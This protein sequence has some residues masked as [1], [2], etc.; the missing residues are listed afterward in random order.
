VDRSRNRSASLQFEPLES[1]QMMAVS[2][3]LTTGG[4]L[5][6]FGSKYAEQVYF[7]QS[8]GYI[9]VSGVSQVWSTS[10][11][12][13][14]YVDMGKGNDVVSFN[15]LGNGGNEALAEGISVGKIKGKD[16]FGCAGN[17]N[18]LLGKKNSISQAANGAVT[19]NGLVQSWSVPTPPN[20]PSPPNPPTPP[21]PTNW[22]DSNVIDAALRSL[23]HNLYTDGRI[24]RNDMIN[25]LRNAEDGGIIDSTELNDLRSV[26]SNTTLFGSFDYVWKLSSYV[27]N[28]N[29]ANAKYQGTTLGNLAAGSTTAQMEKLI[30]KWF[31]GLDRP[32]AGGTYRQFTGQL[33]VGGAAYTDIHQGA[34]G[35]CYFVA[36]LG[37]TALKNPSAIS[38][39][40]VVNGDG[41]YTVR[42]YNGG[43]A[44][45]VTVDSYLPT[46]GAGNLIYANYGANYNNVNAE[47]WTALAEKAYVQINE[48]GWL[49]GGLPGNGQNAY[50]AIEGG[51]IYQALGQITGQGTTP[52]AFTS[53]ATSFTTFVNAW[54]QGKSIGFASKPTPASSSVVGSHAYAV[55]GY[56]ATNQTITLFNPWGIEYGLVTM[57][58]AQ[59][60]QNFS[61]FDRTV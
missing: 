19:V 20:P 33:F 38:N 26:V 3:T 11:V 22:F 12:N 44:Q 18:Y 32:T 8:N 42:F 50:S 15:S 56:N 2:A 28:A 24:D 31:L 41:T 58:W 21:D 13:A 27:V 5:N 1:R 53:G 57:T 30:N 47:L 51:Y 25:L 16:L 10:Q 14:I 60:Q 48:M 4:V 45:Y 39:M 49:R 37:E 29:A 34:L 61:Y 17:H 6:I 46:N 55:V 36:S 43:T 23:G 9:C 54:N 35:D 40:F 52:F 59:I 7:N